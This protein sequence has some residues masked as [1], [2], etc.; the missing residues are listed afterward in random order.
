[1]SDEFTAIWQ[2]C[3]RCRANP[4]SLAAHVDLVFATYDVDDR[5]GAVIATTDTLLGLGQP[6]SVR[7]L[8]GAA[9]LELGC[10]DKALVWFD[11]DDPDLTSGRVAALALRGDGDQ[12]RAT[13]AVLTEAHPAWRAE[14]LE[15]LVAE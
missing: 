6:D 15:R 5:E 13:Y 9:L 12:A 2:H 7:Y 8:L 11:G 10:Y 1:M 14:R 4:H 3:E